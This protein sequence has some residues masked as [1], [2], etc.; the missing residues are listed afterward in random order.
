MRS[1]GLDLTVKC[2]RGQHSKKESHELQVWR[3]GVSLCSEWPPVGSCASHPTL[4][5]S[6]GFC[7]CNMG[8]LDELTS[9][10]SSS[11]DASLDRKGHA[12]PLPF[13]YVFML[14]PKALDG[15]FPVTCMYMKCA[16]SE[17]TLI[18]LGTLIYFN[19]WSIKQICVR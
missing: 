17:R 3:L 8:G 18:C 11:F 13:G 5:A 6:V 16:V 4:R 2:G 15:R 9:K 7:V 19:L 10:S 1:N 14:L 12:F